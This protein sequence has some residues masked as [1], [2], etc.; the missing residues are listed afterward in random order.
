MQFI[1]KTL[2]E[3]GHILLRRN[4]PR[5]V[6]K[7]HNKTTSGRHARLVTEYTSDEV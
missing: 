4:E 5:R 2:T 3:T 7:R 1:T 6:T